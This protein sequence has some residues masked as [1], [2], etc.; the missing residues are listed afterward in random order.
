MFSSEDGVVPIKKL[1]KIRISNAFAKV[2]I[3]DKR[4]NAQ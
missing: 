3:L 1:A 2:L 4:F